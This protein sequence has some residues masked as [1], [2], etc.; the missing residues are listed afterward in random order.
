M[1]VCDFELM[2]WT[3]QLITVYAACPVINS[4]SNSNPWISRNTD[5]KY[6]MYYR[7]LMLDSSHV[8]FTP[9]IE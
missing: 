8:R 4:N 3:N 7:L 5:L 9:A 2:P 1:Y 6:K